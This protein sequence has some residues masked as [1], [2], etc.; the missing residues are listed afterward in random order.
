MKSGILIAVLFSSIQITNGQPA[1]TNAA[2]ERAGHAVAL[3][4]EPFPLSQVHLLDSPFQKA[5]ARD[6]D[7]LLN[8]DCDRLLYNFRRN[9][10][11]PTDAKPY[12]GWED[13]GCELRASAQGG[14]RPCCEQGSR[15]R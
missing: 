14:V 8:L 4:A 10:G 3:A 11:L 9:A 2:G 12:G 1:I 7:Y 6:R 15:F 13:P 5:M